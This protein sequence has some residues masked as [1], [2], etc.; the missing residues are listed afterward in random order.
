MFARVAT[1][2]GADSAEIDGTVEQMRAGGRPEGVPATAFYLLVDRGSG[3]TL[4][5]TLFE[6]EE[7][8]RTG[9]AALEAMSPP[10]GAL[11]RRTSVE[12]FEVP[13]QMS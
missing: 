4:G 2:E 9:S 1:F 11:G 6:T 3:K 13:L 10:T 5:I 7:D 8:L 12:T